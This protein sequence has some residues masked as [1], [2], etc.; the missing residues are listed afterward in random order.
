MRAGGADEDDRLARGQRA[1][2]VQVSRA[3]WLA[4]EKLE[5]IIAD[6]HSGTR[7]WGYVAASNYPAEPSISG[8]AGFSRSVSINETDA[9]LS[10][11]G[12]GYKTVTVSVGFVD[13]KGASRSYS[14][15][16]VVTDYSP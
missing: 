3:R 1:D 12:L 16:T 2:P 5:D 11:A 13:G 15:A 8:F 9:T 7:G 10:T 4:T 14:L 6:R